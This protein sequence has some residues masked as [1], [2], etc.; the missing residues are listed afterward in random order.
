MTGAALTQTTFTEADYTPL[1]HVFSG[2]DISK[3]SK[4]ELERFAVMLS[5]P[6]AYTHFGDRDYLQICETV[7]T[8]IL[9]RISEDANKE[10]TQNSRIAL[11]VALAALVIA[12]AQAIM[13]YLG[14]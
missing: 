7:R 13:Q 3:A 14:V 1:T 5:R 4:L 6:R 8:L 2:G 9:V 12:I 10:A 11:C